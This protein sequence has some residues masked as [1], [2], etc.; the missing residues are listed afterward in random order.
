MQQ[1]SV[2]F[3]TPLGCYDYLSNSELPI[4]TFVLAPFGRKKL[5]GIVWD[6]EANTHIDKSKIKEIL[7]VLP[8]QPL[9]FETIQ[10]VN[11]VSSYTLAPLGA[12]LKMALVHI[13]PE[14][15]EN[16]HEGLL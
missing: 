2:L 15:A 3:P 6:K 11:W 9:P 5:I 10:F 7:E 12:V 8:Y 13:F 4:G 14:L 16:F 1:I